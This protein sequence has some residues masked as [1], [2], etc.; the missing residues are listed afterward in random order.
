[1]SDDKPVNSNSELD[2]SN[3]DKPVNSNSES[4]NSQITLIIAIAPIIAGLLGTIF[5][6]YYK[7]ILMYNWKGK[8][9]SS[10]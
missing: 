8:N 2:S 7:G 5:G 9:L 4:S 10:H 6:V 1:M 3:D